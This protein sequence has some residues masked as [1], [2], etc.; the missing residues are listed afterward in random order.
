MAD[1]TTSKKF[2]IPMRLMRWSSVAVKWPMGGPFS[3]PDAK[4][5]AS[6]G[7]LPAYES[8][9]ELTKHWGGDAPYITVEVIQE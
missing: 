1:K 9:G 3:L 8:L 7:F 5:E 6:V 4:V 2:Y